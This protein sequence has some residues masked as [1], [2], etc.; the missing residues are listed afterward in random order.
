MTTRATAGDG[1]AAT[2]APFVEAIG[3]WA[4]SLQAVS[5]AREILD[6]RDPSRM[7]ILVADMVNGFCHAGP[8]SSE[9]VRGIVAPVVRLLE[10]AHAAG[11]PHYLLFRDT[12]RDDAEEFSSY[13]AHCVEGTEEAETVPELSGLP[14]ADR[15]VTLP[16]NSISAALGTGFDAWLSE[17]PEVTEFVAVGNCTDLCLY[18]LVLHTKLRGNALHL[19]Y[20]VTVP[21]DCAQTFD[22]GVEAARSLGSLPHDGD[23]LHALFL[24]H[25][26]L[27]GVNVVGSVVA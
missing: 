23:L 18:Q 6:G 27:N 4:G 26:A 5:L 16:K 25:M 13:P 24:H 19:G 9:R 7:A 2:S 22:V 3:E 8:L 10:A 1:L 14:F 12:H 15:F 20:R 11:V 17:H 21:A